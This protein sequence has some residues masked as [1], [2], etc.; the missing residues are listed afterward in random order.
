MEFGELFGYRCRCVL[1]MESDMQKVEWGIVWCVV[2]GKVGRF[3][4]Y[5]GGYCLVG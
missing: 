4:C 2:Q 3:C 1:L 5:S